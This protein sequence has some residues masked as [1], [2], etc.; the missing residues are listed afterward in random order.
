MTA[1]VD[2]LGEQALH[3]H[4]VAPDAVEF[5]VLL[6][7][8]DLLE[9]REGHEVQARAVLGK[10]PREKLPEASRARGVRQ[11]GHGG[12]TD[13]RAAHVTP[14]VD[15]EFPDAGVAAA[16]GVRM[17]YRVADHGAGRVLD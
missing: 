13:P 10:D 3:D 2:V 14:D 6:V 12:A 8:A 5:A 4:A 9:A 17:G 16:V 15:R 1:S 11:G 7:H